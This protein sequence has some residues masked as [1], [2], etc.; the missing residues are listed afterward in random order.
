MK[1][2][3]YQIRKKKKMIKYSIISVFVLFIVGALLFSYFTAPESEDTLQRFDAFGE[4]PVPSSFITIAKSL[5]NPTIAQQFTFVN[6]DTAQA[7]YYQKTTDPPYVWEHTPGKNVITG[8]KCAVGEV[9]LFKFCTQPNNKASCFANMFDQL[10]QVHESGDYL[11]MTEYYINDKQFYYS[12]TCYEPYEIFPDDFERGFLD[13]NVCVG[14]KDASSNAVDYG[15]ELKCLEALDKKIQAEK[16]SNTGGATEPTTQDTQE[17]LL[18]AAEKQC[19]DEGGTFDRGTE[20]CTLPTTTDTSITK[21][22]TTQTTSNTDTTTQSTSDTTNQNGGEDEKIPSVCEPYEEYVNNL[23]CEF[24]INKLLSDQGF[25]AYY[26]KNPAQSVIGII[27]LLVII[28]SG[29][30]YYIKNKKG[31]KK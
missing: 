18:Q 9:I 17:A 29:V 3:S 15:T 31:G 16:D 25:N 21:D 20:V 6:V 1:K 7:L 19:N 11:V 12:Y 2:R 10:W 26:N 23:Y 28:F 24:R 5:I 4:S 30:S 14:A 8:G 13:G 27:V 22:T